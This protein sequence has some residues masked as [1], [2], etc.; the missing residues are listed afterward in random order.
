MDQKDQEDQDWPKEDSLANTSVD[1]TIMRVR[2]MKKKK[3][4]KRVNDITV[5]F[6]NELQTLQEE[7]NED[8][9]VTKDNHLISNRV[10]NA[11]I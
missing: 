10:L 8:E 4:K 5:G 7:I 3:K 9:Q 6:E 1:N 11:K 2:K